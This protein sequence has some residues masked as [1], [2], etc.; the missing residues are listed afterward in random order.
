MN[1]KNPTNIYVI[2]YYDHENLGDE[3]YKLT[4]NYIF[5][6]FLP[7]TDLQHYNIEFLDCDKI[8]LK[9]FIDSDII[10]LGGGDIINEYFLD[11]IIL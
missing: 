1:I 3:T 9:K 8:N 6:T 7:K 5:D 10:V 2:G 11:Q 4:F